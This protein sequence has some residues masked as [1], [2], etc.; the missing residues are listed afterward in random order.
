MVQL[1]RDYESKIHTLEQRIMTS[2]QSK[3][4]QER[5]ENSNSQ[6]MADMLQKLESRVLNLD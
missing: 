2:E 4:L 1:Q 3:E 5:Q 6:I